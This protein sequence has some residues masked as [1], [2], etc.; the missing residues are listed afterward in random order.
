MRTPSVLLAGLALAL[1]PAATASAKEIAS[2]KAC[3]ADGC[4]DVTALATHVA[5][6]GG[7]PTTAPDRAAPFYRLRITIRLDARARETW[8]NVYVPAAQKIRGDD[9][10]WMNPAS[11]TLD[12]LDRLV[13]GSA[14]LPAERL[15]LPMPAAAPGSVPAPG[16]DGLPAVVWAFLAAGGLG[17]LAAAAGATRTLRRRGAAPAG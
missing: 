16:G 13:E 5:L 17:V 15:G 14:A 7:P 1:A 10:T 8:T 2:V 12:A 9:G 11:T 6:D 3:G 4:R